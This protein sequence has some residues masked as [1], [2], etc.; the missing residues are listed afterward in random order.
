MKVFIII[1][2]QSER[3]E[4][5]NF[6]DLGDLPL[7]QHLIYEL[8]GHD[9]YID[10]DSE[11]VIKKCQEFDWVT[12]YPREQK[13]IDFET[14]NKKNLS[15]ALLMIEN[16]LDIYVEDEDE[17]I[18]TTH[19]TSPFLK[20]A[21]I[22]KAARILEKE[23]KYDSVHS[24]TTHHEFS[25]LGEDMKPINFKP[26]VVQKTQDL[27]AITMSNGGFFIFRKS[28]FMKEKN[29]IGKSPYYYTLDTPEDIEIDNMN[30]L[31]LARLVEA[32]M[33][34]EQGLWK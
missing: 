18:V 34:T 22:E 30:D 17:I 8:Q 24:V 27:P 14:S 7:W 25:W 16:F 33:L 32:G 5:K 9:V 28:L 10:T 23:S 1:K 15:P 29:R 2:D 6:Q 11:D 21:T 20:A 13:F 12:A 4:R 3:I 26:N 31:R 19:V